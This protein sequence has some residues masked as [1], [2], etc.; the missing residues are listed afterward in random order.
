ME[1]LETLVEKSLDKLR[2]LAVRMIGTNDAD[3]LVGDTLLAAVEAW[4]RYRGESAP[5]TWL[6]SILRR[7]YYATLRRNRYRRTGKLEE[8]GVED[9]TV[10][11]HEAAELVQRL[12][13]KLRETV[14]RFYYCGQSY[15]EIAREMS[16]PIGTVRSRLSEAKQ[17]L[18]KATEAA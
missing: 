12:D 3:D 5:E 4:P 6:I 2:V 10:E 8:T 16:V 9:N 7:Q 17:R 14:I 1:T 13:R 18:K 11:L 15:E